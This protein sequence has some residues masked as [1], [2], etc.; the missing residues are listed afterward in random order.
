MSL[1]N[2]LDLEKAFQRVQQDKRDDSWPDIANYK[3]YELV[4]KEKL[5]ILQSQ[6]DKPD[7][8]R[9][10]F[11]FH[12][13]I[14]KKGFTL[15]PVDIPTIDDRIIYQAIAD[16]LSPHF[17]PESCVYS[18][19]LSLNINST[20]M[21]IPGVDLWLRFQKE[22]ERLCELFPYVVETDI[23]TY[24]EYI[25]HHRL[26]HRIQDLFEN[27]IDKDI[28]NAN[29]VLLQR[30]WQ[31]WS[32]GRKVGI[33]QVNDASSFFGNIFLDELDKWMLRRGFV[34]MRY[35]D[36]MRIFAKDEPS[37]RYALAE[38][39]IQLRELG[40]HV[41]SGKTLIRKT[42]VVLSELQDN[43]DRMA[44]IDSHIKS[45]VAP[46]L[47]QAA[48]MLEDFVGELISDTN[49]F[50]DRHFRFC[51]NRFKQLKV[52]G[53]APNIHDNVANLVLERL[54]TMPYET[55]TFVDYL[56]YFPDNEHVQKSVIEFL[57]SDYNIYPWQEMSLL[58]LL[59]RLE[60][61]PDYIDRSL[62]IARSIAKD[63]QKHPA[64]R[65]K[66]LLLWGK[67]GDYADRREIR[68]R[69]FDESRDDVKRAIM[70]AIQ[71]MQ[72]GER[73]N[74]LDSVINDDSDSIRL[75]ARYI[76]ILNNPTYHYYHPQ[77]GFDIV[78][79]WES[80]DLDDLPMPSA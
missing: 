35:V 58:E 80:N 4:L 61:L 56:S 38:L 69:Y 31:K 47:E 74:F 7:S 78:E 42:S 54:K 24:F 32:K 11:P 50:N 14:P 71:E 60:I 8:Y 53:V 26:L 51:V 17:Q 12:I 52:N 43:A 2:F 70:L 40:L 5:G 27:K 3:D 62:H 66:A 77:K 6:I 33:P 55:G 18:N 15:R 64:C 68:G 67:N 48:T 20:R 63:N 21:F 22:V 23:A 36:D 72:P 1:I 30:L 79:N 73:K 9:A 49:K 41:G 29:K 57:E 39:V 34:F 46:R 75:T 59:I 76:Q 37:A 19:I 10:N 45:H 13:D 25:D 28:L 16:N 44:L 65:G